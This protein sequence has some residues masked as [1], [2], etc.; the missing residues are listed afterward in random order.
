M[1]E[2]SNSNRTNKPGKKATGTIIKLKDAR[3]QPFITLCEGSRK[4]FKPY[5]R[6]TS[7]AKAREMA[8]ARAEQDQSMGLVSAKAAAKVD[9]GR[10][11]KQARCKLDA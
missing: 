4:R 1:S 3:F 9:E 2:D 10:S 6:G 11:W 7:E 5:P 8:A